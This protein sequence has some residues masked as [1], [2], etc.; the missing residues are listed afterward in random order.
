MIPSVEKGW[1]AK[2]VNIYSGESEFH[3]V[4]VCSTVLHP[5]GGSMALWQGWNQ[6]SPPQLTGSSGFVQEDSR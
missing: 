3:I 4:F 1:A 5:E 6:T 2:A